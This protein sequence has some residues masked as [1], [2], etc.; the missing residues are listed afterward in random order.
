MLSI[1]PSIAF[2][3]LQSV[4]GLPNGIYELVQV[5]DHLFKGI[6]LSRSGNTLLMYRLFTEP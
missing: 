1:G 3:Q 4:K 6:G 2:P 5:Q